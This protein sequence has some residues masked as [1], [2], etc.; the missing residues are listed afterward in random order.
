VRWIRQECRNS[1]P[2]IDRV[3]L[4]ETRGCGA[5]LQWGEL[6]PALPL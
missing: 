1:L 6:G 4:F 5:I 2:Q 3:D